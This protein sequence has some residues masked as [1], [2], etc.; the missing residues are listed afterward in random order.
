MFCL[1]TT[2]RHGRLN[3]APSSGF[4]PQLPPPAFRL[5]ILTDN[6]I[7]AL[8]ENWA[9]DVKTVLTGNRWRL[10]R[11]AGRLRG[12]G[13]CGIA[14]SRFSAIFLTSWRRCRATSL[15]ARQPVIAACRRALTFNLFRRWTNE[16]KAW[17]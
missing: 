10:A 2:I 5:T 13:T 4:D 6:R 14:A 1:T 12:P 7:A 9:A 17:G 11:A 3:P 8:P 16:L 15:Y